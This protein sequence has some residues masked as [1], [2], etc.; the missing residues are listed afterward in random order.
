MSESL[1]PLC[2]IATTLGL[3]T[4]SAQSLKLSGEHPVFSEVVT[5]QDAVRA[6][7]RFVGE[8]YKMDFKPLKKQIP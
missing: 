1:A 4:V 6:V 2:S 5:D 3:A 8:F 7:E